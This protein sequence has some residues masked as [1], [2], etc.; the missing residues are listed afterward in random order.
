MKRDSRRMS[1]CLIQIHNHFHPPDD[2][3]HESRNLALDTPSDVWSATSNCEDGLE[4]DDEA[5][6]YCGTQ[7]NVDDDEIAT[8]YGDEDGWDALS[9]DSIAKSLDSSLLNHPPT[10]KTSSTIDEISKSI[11]NSDSEEYLSCKQCPGFL[12][13]RNQLDQHI[14]EAH[15]WTDSQRAHL[16]NGWYWLTAAKIHRPESSTSSRPTRCD[17]EKTL[18]CPNCPKKFKTAT[19]LANH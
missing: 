1:E 12:I 9:K 14:L 6:E 7:S 13:L 15:S 5:S 4:V 8:N 19:S 11:L 18:A 10:P 17:E 2:I 16:I 3:I